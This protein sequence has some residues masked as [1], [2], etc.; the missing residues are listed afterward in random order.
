MAAVIGSLPTT[1]ARP[2]D[3]EGS[4]PLKNLELVIF[5]RDKRDGSGQQ[6]VD[7]RAGARECRRYRA[8]S[9]GWDSVRS[10]TAAAVSPPR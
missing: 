4:A 9:L 7:V 5:K 3:A 2:Q 1:T 8:A 10:P 6:L